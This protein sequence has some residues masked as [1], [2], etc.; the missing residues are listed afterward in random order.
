LIKVE[1]LVKNYGQVE[2]VKSISFEVNA[3]EIVG[4]LGENGAGK[5]TTL[6]IISGYLSQT[7]GSV[8]IDNMNSKHRSNKIKKMI[9]YL[10]ELNPL[11]TDMRVYDYLKF[12][13]GTY[14][15]KNIEF[16]T[17]LDR[18]IEQCG[19]SGV[20][21]KRIEECSK[22]YKQ[23]TGL[24]SAL[25]H[26][27]KILL[28]DEPVSGLDPNQRIEIRKLI[29]ELGKDKAV[30]V[31]SHNLDQIKATVDRMIIIDNGEIVA[32]GTSDQL[33]ENSKGITTLNMEIK[34]SKD[35]KEIN[36]DI[37][38]VNLIDSIK[39]EDV[40]FLTFEYPSLRDAR[41]DIFNFALKNKWVVLGMTKTETSLEDVFRT[42]TTEGVEDA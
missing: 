21:H 2:A 26:D 10:P 35:I 1:N 19:L 3:G 37:D 23:R 16:N 22:G 13:A 12:I 32:N 34:T 24:A 25:I 29:Q 15:I 8:L 9:G 41:E 38:S 31:S 5:S 30:M 36:F 42:L 11:Y 4:F 17:S 27:P 18:V 20:V 28:L 39:K 14:N 7:S 40:Y 33:M 6:K